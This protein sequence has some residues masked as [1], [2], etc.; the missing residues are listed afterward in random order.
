MQK[1][2]CKIVNVIDKV[3]GI[4]FFSVFFKMITSRYQIILSVGSKSKND[5]VFHTTNS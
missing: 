3:T 1:E 2:A 4:F 5:S